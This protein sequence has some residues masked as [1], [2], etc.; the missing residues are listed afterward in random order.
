MLDEPKEIEPAPRPAPRPPVDHRPD[1]LFVTHVETLV[2]DPYQV[3]ARQILRLYPLDPPDM[4]MDARVRGTAIH[5]AFEALSKLYEEGTIDD[6]AAEFERLY[7]DALDR[8]GLPPS[9][10]PRERALAKEAARWVADFEDRRRADLAFVAAERRGS[11]TFRVA[12]RDFTLS[13][14]TDRIEVTPDGY[15]HVLDF[16]TGGS[17]SRAQV[18]QGYSPQLTLTAAIL[19]HGAFDGIPANVT[20]GELV[21]VE[22][23]GRR[24]AGREE[25]RA[26]K[27]EGLPRGEEALDGLKKVIGRFADPKTPYLSR[28]APQF[29]KTYASD[30]DHLARVYEWSTAGADEGGE[31]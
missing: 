12:G 4:R 9:A 23:T 16:K 20:P 24:P 11:M 28:I 19:A 27:D 10:L 3:W 14:K 29:V 26:Q 1:R 25:Y 5:E 6:A 18:E 15:A 13:A 30:Y 31:G 8:A 22:I 17:P 7:L 2:R 21:Y